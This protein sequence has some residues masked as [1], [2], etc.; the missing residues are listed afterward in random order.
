MHN[1]PFTVA[2]M[3]TSTGA[4]HSPNLNAWGGGNPSSS[5]T[6]PFSDSL[7]QSRSHYQSGYLMS[8]S[9]NNNAPQGN[10]RVD[11]PPIV[12][13]KAKMN[14]ILSRGSASDFGMESMFE[15]S[16]QRKN[17][18]DEDAP[19]TNSINDIPNDI[20]V[21]SNSNRF[22]PRNS[23]LDNSTSRRH[24]RATSAPQTSQPLYII[25]FGYPQDRYSVT[26]E[27]FRSLGESTDA[28]PNTE[29]TNCFRIGYKDP[30]D[31]MRAV[32]K[33]GEILGGSWMV[34]VK[35]ADP[36]HAESLLGQPVLRN[37]LPDPTPSNAM[38]VDESPS[39]ISHAVSST[40]TLGTPIKL[41]PSASAFRR[42]GTAEKITGSPAQ[43]GWG[44]PGGNLLPSAAASSTQPPNKGMLGQVSDLIFGW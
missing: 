22:Q 25:V 7:S 32:R 17:L 26:V 18:A 14:H 23:V 31:A 13:T 35:W 30:G 42:T 33:N 29:I 4:H 19:P 11:E 39:P 40:P 10:Q 27:Y 38:A 5:L 20:H 9:Q 44:P 2:G 8:T 21:N 28:D 15:S 34:G 3:S 16:R 36:A 1:S 37:Q 24:S 12:Q 41:A 43:R 6:T